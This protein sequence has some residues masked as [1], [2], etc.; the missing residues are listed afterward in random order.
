MTFEGAM[1]SILRELGSSKFELGSSKF[2]HCLPIC[3]L[4]ISFLF[5]RKDQTHQVVH[6][7]TGQGG[8]GVIASVVNTPYSI[9][10][11]VLGDANSKKLTAAK[12]V[13][14]YG[15][16]AEATSSSVSYAVMDKG[17][18]MDPLYNYAILADASSSQ[19]WP[20]TGMYCLLLH[21]IMTY[22]CI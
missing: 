4:T 11:A 2:E 6:H 3:I 14:K 7:N 5:F 12:M 19:A 22:R 9:G 17:G 18:N 8:G 1:V 15:A 16:L 21:S 13:N 10:Y 20:M